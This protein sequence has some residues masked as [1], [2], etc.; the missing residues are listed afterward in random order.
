MDR[1]S[2]DGHP[3]VSE[4]LN[5]LDRV[6]DHLEELRPA[7]LARPKQ[8]FDDDLIEL[9]DEVIDAKAEDVAPLA[10]QMMRVAAIRAAR[11]QAGG[12]SV[13][14][15]PESPYFGHL[16]LLEEERARDIFIGKRS[17]I[18]ASAGVVIVDWRNAPISSLYYRYDEGDDYD[19]HIAG[20]HREGLVTARRTLSVVEGNLRRVSAPQGVF[21]REEDGSFRQLED[22]AARLRGG[23]GMALRPKGPVFVSRK[24][25]RRR[26]S[27]DFRPGLRPDKHLPEISALI[28]PRQFQLITREKSGILI[29]TGGAG[30]GKTTIGL[31]RIAFLA[32]QRPKKYRSERMLVVVPGRA[33]AS[34]VGRVL[35]DLG[36]TDV[37]V[38]TQADWLRRQRKRAFKR[39]SIPS[40]AEPLDVVQRVKKHPGMLALVD[41]VAEE[42]LQRVRGVLAKALQGRPSAEV[43]LDA[44]HRLREGPL[45]GQLDGLLE[46]IR[47]PLPDG[48]SR[49]PAQ[50]Q[51]AVTAALRRVMPNAAQVIELWAELLTNRERLSTLATPGSGLTAANIEE[52]VRS[53]MRQTAAV[54]DAVE[55]RQ[56]SDQERSKR[57]RR[58]ADDDSGPWLSSE[59]DALLLRLHQRLIGELAVRSG[60]RLQYNHLMVDEVQ[61]LSVVELAVVLSCVSSGGSVTMAG[62][63]AQRMVFDTGYDGWSELLAALSL[64]GVE[65][66]PLRIGYRSTAEIQR[67][68]RAVLGPMWSDD[69]PQASRPGVP[70]EA[71]SFG[72]PG[73]AVVFLADAL[74]DLITQEPLASVALIARYPAQAEMYYQALRGAEITALRRVTHQDFSFA[75]GIEVTDI[76]QVKGLEFDYVLLLD[77]NAESYNDTAESRHLLHIAA[78]RAAHQLWLICPGSSSPVLPDAVEDASDLHTRS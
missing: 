25:R 69:A 76:R 53:C 66:S 9:R 29:V 24:K 23:Q 49:L 44:T 31:H 56:Y 17:Y 51:A 14:V 8:Q 36:L 11:G 64:D 39:L 20:R 62:D 63:P 30:S 41:E 52:A 1:P 47:K 48:S 60:K 5:Q 74:R 73:E 35:P 6:R 4:E 46:W 58:A 10:E 13:P 21:V 3:V 2:D 78:T 16:R 68:A 37:P 22:E 15:D 7:P 38:T 70:V 27:K 40:G 50:T 26:P 55:A 45:L 77:V 43:V 61:D 33:L 34:Y 65:V 75:P 18:N 28:D 54:V 32:F 42:Q 67:F 72:D 59:D 57:E 12:G 71:F 19:E